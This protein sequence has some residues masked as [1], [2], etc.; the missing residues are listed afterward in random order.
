MRVFRDQEFQSY[1]DRDSA[2]TFSDIE[3]CRCYFE[4][5]ALSIARRPPDRSTIRNIRLLDCSQ[6]GCRLDS[7]IV[8][9]V[10][11]DGLKT[12]GQLLQTWGAVFN[13]VVLRGKIDRLMISTDVFPSILMAEAD[14]RREIDSFRAENAEY[15]RRVD[16]ALDISQ[17]E[18]KE[19]DIRGVPTH[20]I[21][22]DA[23]T[24][25]VV[26]RKKALEGRWKEL[27][28][29]ETLWRTWLEHFLQ[30]EEPSTILA[31]PKR[32]V[33]FRNYLADLRLLQNSGVAE[34]D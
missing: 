15:Y 5:C 4:S 26:T 10:L 33:K 18:F 21:R 3:F 32:H 13:R 11:V 29:R 25:V 23:E 30:T 9:D 2:A 17:G 7:A 19:L 1:Y 8:E 34:V 16:W 6:R 24:Q 14:R 12:H 20:L 22:R 31:A 27:E 28:F